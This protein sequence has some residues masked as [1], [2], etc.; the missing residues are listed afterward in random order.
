MS[1]ISRSGSPVYEQLRPSP[2]I[3]LGQFGPVVAHEELALEQLHADDGE[4]ELEQTRDQH[5]VP[6]GFDGD[7]HALDHVLR[8][9]SG[10]SGT[11]EGRRP[12]RPRGDG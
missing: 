7:D 3:E 4:H 6:D 8:T 9:G 10:R 11:A 12:R 1:H 5:N 2:A